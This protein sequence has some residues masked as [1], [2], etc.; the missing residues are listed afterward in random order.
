[1]KEFG[2]VPTTNQPKDF[3][4]TARLVCNSLLL[5][6]VTDDSVFYTHFNPSVSDYVLGKICGYAEARRLVNCLDSLAVVKFYSDLIRFKKVRRNEAEAI[7]DFLL[8]KYGSQLDPRFLASL[9]L[10]LWL[11]KETQLLGDA[12]KLFKAI[13]I[14]S[15]MGY[16]TDVLSSILAKGYS[17]GLDLDTYQRIIDTEIFYYDELNFLYSSIKYEG[18][19]SALLPVIREQLVGGLAGNMDDVVR[20]SDGFYDCESPSDVDS[21]AESVIENLAG[22]YDMLTA[23]DLTE[24]KLNVSASSLFERIEEWRGGYDEPVERPSVA[25][26]GPFTR[27]NTEQSII[28]DMFGNYS[29]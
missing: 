24:L 5:R 29:D 23:D 27:P 13:Q 28:D 7:S 21:F 11:E 22:E 20:D 16:S 2:F 25:T 19:L 12:I 9:D 26:P 3:L 10:A 15:S 4:H 14:G 17:F 8:G 1:M 6:N 18:S